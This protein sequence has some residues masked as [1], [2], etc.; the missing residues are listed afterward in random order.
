LPFTRQFYG[1]TEKKS[2]LNAFN[3]RFPQKGLEEGK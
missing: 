1:D 3:M 2:T